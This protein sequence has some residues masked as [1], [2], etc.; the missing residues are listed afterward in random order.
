MPGAGLQG[1]GTTSAGLGT[2]ASATAQ[3]GAFLRDTKTGISHGARMID[4]NTRDYVL[5][6]NGRILGLDY[7][8]HAVQMS[9]HTDRGSSAVQSMGQRLRTLDRITPNF[10]RRVLAILTEALQPLI[11]LGYIEVLG[12]DQFTAGSAAN[13]LMPGAVFGRLRWRDL[14][15]GEEEKELI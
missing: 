5:D 11:T 6:D 8:K 12:F 9:I 15:T 14:T 4:P 7:V 10:E 2:S 1:G 3:G 13:G